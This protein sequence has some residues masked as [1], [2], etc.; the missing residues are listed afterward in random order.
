MIHEHEL[1]L[2]AAAIDFE[3]TPAERRRLDAAIADCSICSRAAASYRRDATMM[4]A[5][6]VVDASPTVRRQVERAAGL[7]PQRTSLNWVLLAA[8]MLGLLV[9]SALVVGAISQLRRN[10]L[11]QVEPSPAPTQTPAPSSAP[12]SVPVPDVIALDPPSGDLA[13]VGPPLAHDS[14]ALVVTDNLRIRSA[15]FVGDLSTKYQRLL[16][17]GDRLFVIDGPVIAQNYEW[18]QVKAWRPRSPSV[19]WPVGWVARA[20]HDGEVWFRST[21]VGC[22][23]SPISVEDVVALA[24]AD[25]LAC[26]RDTTLQIRAVVGTA[27]VDCDPARSGCPTG[28]E[29][30]ARSALRA[31]I[32]ASVDPPG[33]GV[34]IALDPGAGLDPDAIEQA[35]VVRLDGTF[36]HPDARSCGPDPQRA[37]P[38]GPITP[39]EAVLECRTRFVVTAVTPETFPRL[40][41]VAGKTVSDRLRVRSLPEIS[42]ASIKYEP[43]LPLGT[44]VTILDGPVLGNGYAWYHVRAIVTDRQRG[45]QPI[46]LTGW[47]AAADRDGERWL[48]ATKP[49]PSPSS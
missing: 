48:Q 45:T 33:A 3:L 34:P 8:A 32:S 44:K 47:V 46:E 39:I 2:A 41:E 9:T 6:P 28:P 15:P 23:A 22:P 17:D 25:R 10:D 35:G 27:P 40:N 42:D 37:G 11:S 5:L 38:D 12:P 30:L 1:E 29:W 20:G 31:S 13:N 4:A 26:Y 18:Y 43:L 16:D 36:D 49:S 24:P 14:M 19:S 7:R 21:T